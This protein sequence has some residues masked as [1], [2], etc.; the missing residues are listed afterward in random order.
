VLGVYFHSNACEYYLVDQC[1]DPGT[2]ALRRL[3]VMTDSRC[4]QT[5]FVKVA[6]DLESSGFDH[7]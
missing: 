7:R 5:Q 2:V 4:V 6:Y 1:F 3:Y